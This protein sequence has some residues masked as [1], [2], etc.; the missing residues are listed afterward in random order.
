MIILSGV[1]SST[2]KHAGSADPRLRVELEVPFCV[3][4][5]IVFA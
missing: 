2:I 1:M 4:K 3:S 5:R